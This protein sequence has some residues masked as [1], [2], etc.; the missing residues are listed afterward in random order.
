MT[1]S[2]GPGPTIPGPSHPTDDADVAGNGS[3]SRSDSGS[4]LA[5]YRA[6]VAAGSLAP[7]PAQELA[8]EK[9][10]SLARAL[11]HYRPGES[12][13]WRARLGLARRP[14][15]PPQGLYLCGSVGR[16]KSMLM[17]VFFAAA[18]PEKKR[19]THFHAFMLDVHERLHRRRQ[20][21]AE[22]DPI[23]PLARELAEEAWLLC[24]D[25]FQV[26]NIADA[27]ILG[28]LF[29]GLFEAGVVV[30]ATS[31]TAPDDLYAGGLQRDR[32]LP[33]IA[34]LK[35]KLDL[36]ELDGRTD[37]RRDRIKG[38]AV[39]H[40]PLGAAATA[41]L[42]AAFSSLTDGVA[43]GPVELPVQGR[44]LTVPRA[45]LGVA[46]ARFF[47]LCV[48]PLGAADFLAVAKAFHTLVLDDIP[49]LSA[50][51]RNEARRF[52]TL[53]DALYEHRT[54]L[55]CAAAAPPDALHE[56]GDHAAEFRRTASRL[57][58]MQSASFLAEP[59]LD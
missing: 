27:M 48:R 19:R 34:L 29:A 42:D 53:V 32:F 56:A 23:A 3:D 24:F 4:P 38:M 1:H 43:A 33:A 25:E 6:R 30:V 14:E 45:A 21:K 36:L 20:R 31:N 49:V 18:A 26:T 37:Y 7:D 16:G 13:G 35:D 10:E 52:I 51:K 15:P 12:G 44:I 59:H 39:Y 28:R 54:K 40:C 2:S 55:V 46:R 58:E 9:L 41:A 5:V 50:E 17:D 47:D 57:H 11:H 8:A 22:Q